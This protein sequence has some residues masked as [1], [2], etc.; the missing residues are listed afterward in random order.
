MKRFIAL[1]SACGVL[2]AL[3]PPVTAAVF[4]GGGGSTGAQGPPG[5]ATNAIDKTTG[6]GTNTSFH[7]SITN[8]G[9]L[10][11]VG[12]LLHPGTSPLLFDDDWIFYQDGSSL[13]I[14][15]AATGL[16]A[17][18]VDNATGAVTTEGSATHNG[19]ATFASGITMMD[20]ITANSTSIVNTLTADNTPGTNDSFMFHDKE[21]A[22]MKQGVLNNLPF[23]D[24]D[25]LWTA[26]FLG[27]AL[28]ELNDLINAGVPNGTGAKVHW[29]QLL[30]VPAG[31]ADGTDDGGSGTPGGNT[32]ELQ[33]NQGGALDGTNRFT[34]DRT[35]NRVGLNIP[36]ARPQADLEIGGSAPK[37]FVGATANTNEMNSGGLNSHSLY[38]A[39]APRSIAAAGSGMS[40]RLDTNNWYANTSDSADLGGSANLWRHAYI[41]Q[42]LRS[43]TIINTG[44]VQSASLLLTNYSPGAYPSGAGWKET[45][46]VNQARIEGAHRM[47]FSYTNRIGVL[48][49][50]AASVV[51]FPLNELNELMVT[52]PISGVMTMVGTNGTAG[53][54][55]RAKVRGEA[56]GGTD[57]VFTYVPNTGQLVASMDSLATGM[58]LSFTT[59]I[60]NGYDLE[61]DGAIDKIQGTNTHYIVTRLSKR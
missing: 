57:R 9:T 40:F 31:I 32:T 55:F 16:A 14:S 25:N 54:K 50:S 21:S 49:V 6:N 60:T 52:N 44:E 10:R 36:G 17:L 35:N 47:S 39:F 61:L 33:F 41:S 12:P 15:N 22:S 5:S 45:N 34:I 2:L 26:G 13:V 7:G 42:V 29:S 19:S 51:E 53:T 8:N 56:S 23:G 20:G 46:G 43:G 37:I 58:A 11:Q 3:T 18:K 28:A 38:L 4:G 24:P 27:T 48:E 59:T 30:G 1:L